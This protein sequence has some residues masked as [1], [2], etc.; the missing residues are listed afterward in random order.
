MLKFIAKKVTRRG[1]GSKKGERDTNETAAAANTLFE[2]S[3]ANVSRFSDLLEVAVR[4]KVSNKSSDPLRI[5]EDE[6]TE[7]L[8][9]D[10]TNNSLSKTQLESYP[11]SVLWSAAVQILKNSKPL[12]EQESC[13]TLRSASFDDVSQLARSLPLY[14]QKLIGVLCASAEMFIRSE[15]PSAPMILNSLSNSIIWALPLNSFVTT[16]AL[17]NLIVDHRTLFPSCHTF[18]RK[19]STS[20]LPIN[21]EEWRVLAKNSAD[22]YAHKDGHDGN[23]PNDNN[24]NNNDDDGSDSDTGSQA[25]KGPTSNNNKHNNKQNTN[26]NTNPNNTNDT[27]NDPKPGGDRLSMVA[28]SR[29]K[30]FVILFLL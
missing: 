23:G 29:G 13:N 2:F 16:N 9:S 8:C 27:L 14:T 21:A 5:T 10:F 4:S 17:I 26:N 28:Q 6:S 7:Q 25:K 15:P 19:I 24:D 20:F 12:F 1:S 18:A 3:D 30:F 22:I 11:P